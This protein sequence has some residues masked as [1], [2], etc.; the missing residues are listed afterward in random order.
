RGTERPVRGNV[1]LTL[2]V[3]DE[4]SAAEFQ[5]LNLKYGS[6]V[7]LAA[8]LEREEKFLNPGV[9][10]HK[11]VLDQQDIDA[12]GILKSTLLVEK[13]G[14]DAVFSP[15]AWIYAERQSLISE[16]RSRFNPSTSGI[17][18]AS[19]LGDKYF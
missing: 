7:R 10:S 11:A 17:L 3:E 13:I 6:R 14:E 1:R 19:L 15:L 8:N 2:P 5:T 4:Q 9:I 16:F 12:V 18:I